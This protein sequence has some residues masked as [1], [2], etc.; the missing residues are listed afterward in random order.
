MTD[1]SKLDHWYIAYT[2]SK[3]EKKVDQRAREIGL[4]TY[5]PLQ[6]QERQWS[7]RIKKI[8]VPLFPNYI[9]FK[10]RLEDTYQLKQIKE[11]VN[12][13][14]FDKKLA[15]IKDVQ[16]NAIK[17]LLGEK[18]DII[19]EPR[20][21]KVGTKVKIKQGPFVGIEGLLV[22]KNNRDR[23]IIQIETLGQ[24]ISVDIPLSH[25]AYQ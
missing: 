25:L 17:K 3:C 20:L 11:I 7:D 6:L 22:K 16:I 23:F 24:S 19:T 10:S 8:E 21:Y 5:L 12:F 2:Y 15:T 9:F 4:E 14:H 1:L 13:V 18:N